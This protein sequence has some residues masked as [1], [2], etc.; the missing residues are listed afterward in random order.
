VN[1]RD[2]IVLEALLD[3]ATQLVEQCVFEDNTAGNSGGAIFMDFVKQLM[4]VSQCVFLRNATKNGGGGAI[5][6]FNN[7]PSSASPAFLIAQT[8]FEQNSATGQGGGVYLEGEG[9][10][11]V[12][13][14]TFFPNSASDGLSVYHDP[15][16]GTARCAIHGTTA[17]CLAAGSADRSARIMGG[18]APAMA[19]GTKR[20]YA[21]PANL[22]TPSSRRP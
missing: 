2:A 3:T 22:C 6:V 1:Q 20:S 11:N 12:A 15:V 5:S 4:V 18:C 13:F 8:T 17:L 21:A 14:A 10:T 16:G 9:H 19:S 7:Y